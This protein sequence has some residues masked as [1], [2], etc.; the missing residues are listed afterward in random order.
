MKKQCS[1]L[2]FRADEPAIE[3]LVD[4]SVGLVP[5][6][7]DEIRLCHRMVVGD[8]GEGTQDRTRDVLLGCEMSDPIDVVAL[9]TKDGPS[10]VDQELDSSGGITERCCKILKKLIDV[11][12]TYV[13]KNLGEATARQRL[14]REE[15]S[16]FDKGKVVSAICCHGVRPRELSSCRGNGRYKA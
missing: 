11:G 16:G 2:S 3:Q 14:R 8:D 5:A 12:E 9:H 7:P 6:H 15:Q 10:L 4:V 1:P 13:T